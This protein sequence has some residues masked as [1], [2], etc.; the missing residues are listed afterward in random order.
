MAMKKPVILT[1]C[2]P[3]KRIVEE[4]DCGLVV[5]SGDY[6]EMAEAVIRLYKDKEYSRKLGENGRRA[7]EEK[8]NWENEA[9]K[10]CELYKILGE[11]I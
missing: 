7:V 8:Y 4:C 10:L 3:L 1:D 5:P 2:K 11:R 6:N 9:K